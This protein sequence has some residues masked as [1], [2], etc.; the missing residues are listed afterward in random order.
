[1]ASVSLAEPRRRQK[2][3]LNPRG[4]LWANDESKFGQKLMEKMGWEKGRGLGANQDGIVD[5]ITL[6]HKDNNKGVGFQGHDDNWLNHQEDFQS[7]LAALNVEHGDSGKNLDESEKKATLEEISKKSKRRVHYQKFVKGKDSSNYS[8]DDLGCILGTKSEKLKSK[9]EPSSP[10]VE[11]EED[12]DEDKNKNFVQRGNYTDYFAK[13]MAALKAK[14]KFTDVPAWTD[15]QANP[16]NLGL[17]AEKVDPKQK[18]QVDE[19]LEN[20]CVAEVDS[21]QPEKKKKKKSK[22]K[23]EPEEEQEVVVPDEHKKDK[24]KKSKKDRKE[25]LDFDAGENNIKNQES[26]EE[27]NVE[28]ISQK[29]KKSKKNKKKKDELPD[30]VE[31]Q[32]SQLEEIK[33]KKTKKS[34]KEKVTDEEELPEEDSGCENDDSKN[35]K[36][37]KGKKEKVKEK[38]PTY[39][40]EEKENIK[41]NKRKADDEESQDLPVSKKKKSKKNKSCS[42]AT[43]NPLI[44]NP[45][46]IPGFQGSNLLAIPGYGMEAK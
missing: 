15:V 8:A 39:S 13:K 32:P 21:E 46:K 42:T 41:K 22:N 38:K 37:K 34:K 18:D 26:V 45:P 11:S 33:K 7:V 44:E 27:E 1:M 9:S 31:E 10:Q 43:E 6:K 24:K 5:H 16:R 30:N 23:K 12:S 2:W 25:K 3:T 20:K 40:D 17:G 29:K 36:T 19:R 35:K 14:G 28:E 4:N